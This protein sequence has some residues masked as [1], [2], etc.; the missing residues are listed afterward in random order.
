MVH[1]VHYTAGQYMLLAALATAGFLGAVGGTFL[2]R[3]RPSGVPV[4]LAYRVLMSI[5]L[6][7]ADLGTLRVIVAAL[8]VAATTLLLTPAARQTCRDVVSR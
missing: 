1:G 4:T 2:M 5:Y 7:L 3:R 6:W 8:V